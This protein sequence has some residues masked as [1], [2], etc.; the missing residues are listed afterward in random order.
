MRHG[1]CK[2]QKLPREIGSRPAKIA[3]CEA[4]V[5]DRSMS[6]AEAFVAVARGCIAHIV[7]AAEAA[8][9]SDDP[10]AIHQLRVGIRRLRAAFSVFSTALPRRRPAILRQSHA[11]Q[12]QL[13]AARELD[14]LLDETIASMPDDLRNRCEMGEFIKA[15]EEIRVARHRRARAALVSTRCAELLAQLG[16]AIDRCAWQRAHGSVSAK[17]TMRPITSLAAEVMRSR[18]RKARKLGDKMRY[19]SPDDLH[20]LRIRIKKLRY[21]ADFFR[22]LRPGKQTKLYL[23]TLK[24]LQRVLGTMHDATVAAGLIAQIAQRNG[25]EVERAAMLVQRWANTCLK[26][27]ARNLPGLWRRFAKRKSPWKDG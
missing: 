27:E 7:A 17:R 2:T 24:D 14:V 19:L 5:L 10:E 15:A 25:G 20:E 22:D 9:R 16:P 21:A 23:L 4:S 8:R 26:R 13:G 18:H 6:A 11:L 3:Q 12:Q 1:L